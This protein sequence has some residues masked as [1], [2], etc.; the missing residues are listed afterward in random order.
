MKVAVLHPS[1]EGSSSV[2]KELEPEC[3]PARFLP[4]HECINLRIMK[5][6]AAR[7][8]SEIARMGFDVAINLCD[9]AWDED[10]AGIE[11]V[12]ALERVGMA[13]TGAGSDFYDPS[14]EAMKM[15]CHAAGVGFPAYVRD[16][17]GRA[18]RVLRFP[19]IVK[20]PHSYSS[21]GLTPRSRVTD[22][23]QLLCEVV[24]AIEEWGAALIEEFIEG[25]EF[26]VLVAEPR[27]AGLPA[28]PTQTGRSAPLEEAWALAPVEFV[29]P[30]GESFKHFDLKWK[31]YERMETRPVPEPLATRLRE[32]SA[33]MFAA[34]GGS[35]YGR[36]DLRVDAAGEIYAL[37][38]NPYCGIFY[39]DGQFGSADFILAADPAGHRGFLEH[40][41]ACAIRRRDRARRPWELRYERPLGF[42][43]FA[44]RDIHAGE[45]VERYEERPHVLV[46]N[47]YVERNW[48]S[49]RRKWFAE[50]CWPI[51]ADVHVMWSD[52]P[53]DWRPI[54]HSCDPNTCLDGLDVVAR[55]DIARG[56]QV[57]I[58]YATFCGPSMAAFDCRCGSP[59]C[60]GKIG[61]VPI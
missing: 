27:G 9:G 5:A 47:R 26:T 44:N 14:R 49:L 41:I 4:D 12:Q 1:Y 8:V 31:E 43:M 48:R 39:P 34:L 37:E 60:R 23:D 18:L 57:T 59:N 42:G 22:A 10:R 20:H 54:N 21:I 51:S 7:Q 55:R 17:V 38:I 56:E 50:Y 16:D 58:D 33:L 29:F 52:N 6:T 11:V 45:I 24:R 3:D 36:C 28:C 2:F 25:R 19:M 61:T 15:A 13:F 32:A 53:D 46:S 30:E 35:G 40:L